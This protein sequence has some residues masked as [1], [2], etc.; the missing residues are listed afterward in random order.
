M[1][2]YNDN[3][4]A[5]PGTDDPLILEIRE[6]FQYCVDS[7]R[8]IRAEAVKDMKYVAGDPWEPKERKAREDAGRPCISA[9]ELNQY[10]NQ[11]VN[12][13]RQNKRSIKVIPTGAGAD[14]KSAELRAGIIRQ[15]EYKS[16]A[17]S[18]YLT[19]FENA[20]S[21]SYGFFRIT[22]RYVDETSFDQELCIRRIPN[23]DCIYIDPDCKEADC[24]DMKYC[25]VVEP[26]K[27]K[28]FKRQY[29]KAKV[30][31]FTSEHIQAAPLW[32]QEDSVLVGEYWKV[33]YTYTELTEGDKTREVEKRR[34]CQ[35]ITNGLEILEKNE[36]GGMVKESDGTEKWHGKYVPIVPVF[37]KELYI[38]KGHGSE[39]VLMSLIRLARDPQM[40]Y[41]YYRTCQAEVV[42]MTPKTPYIGYEGQFTG[43]EDEWQNVNKAPIPYLQVAPLT[44]ATGTN[45]LPLPQ[46]QAYEPA[47]QSLEMGAESARQAIQ[48]ALGISALP[49][50]AK[51]RNEKSGVALERI[52]QQQA[53]GSYHFIDNFDRAL[54]HG[55][56]ILN[57]YIP[58]VYDTPREI[59]I[60]NADE[61]FDTVKVNQP[62]TDEATK[63]Q[64]SNMLGDGEHDVTI[65]T[66]PSYQSQRD[67][68][69]DFAD[70]IGGNPA[71]IQAALGGSKPAAK[72]LGQTIR[73]K[74]LG[75]LGDEM[76]DA[77]DPPE[78]G[79]EIPPQVQQGIQ[80]L[81]QQVTSLNFYAKQLEGELTQLKQ[82]KEAKVVDNQFKLQQADKD[83]A[84]KIAIAEIETK[85]QSAS[86]RAQIF[87]EVW[88]EIHGAAHEVGM[89]AMQASQPEPQ[90][91][92]AEQPAQ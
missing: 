62:F 56:R 20:A 54:E 38:D 83:N 14:D 39:R 73:L 65:S 45:L 9:D 32:I 37:G 70:S 78:E 71:L 86:E 7:W 23:P 48:S 24:S 41:A 55:G 91:E 13:A 75:V 19:A 35:Y 63:Q 67:Q 74:N 89:G 68:A 10:V 82:E 88:K 3:P 1:A 81:Q 2:D 80:Q 28:E 60:R 51:R 79:P 69:N 42:G 8:D 59:G 30:V 52:E 53:Q 26:M 50:A 34:I 84:T 72:I 61:S 85:A 46:R 40:L 36:W 27:K 25:F 49:T 31:D 92:F 44:D 29:P 15:I 77:I 17:Q 43:H 5:K 64:I 21:R 66:G 18:A 47:I 33:E 16:N 58:V 6:R 12:D 76:A 87:M 11:L 90:D 4:S 22:T 57:D